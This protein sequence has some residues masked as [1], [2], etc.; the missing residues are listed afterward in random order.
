M[1]KISQLE[2]DADRY[3]Y[4]TFSENSSKRLDLNNLL[5]RNKE[6]E[7]KNKKYNLLIFFG[8]SSVALVFVLLFSIQ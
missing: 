7:K 2:Q 6:E 3:G 5:K 8:V 4:K 1:G